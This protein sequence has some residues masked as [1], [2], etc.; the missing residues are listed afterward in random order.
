[1]DGAKNV[2]YRAIP[3][4]PQYRAGSDGSIIG[5]SG[6]LLRLRDNNGYLGFEVQID[7]RG[8]R[9]YAHVAVCEAFHGRRPAGKEVAH[10]NGVRS[11][12]RQENLSWKTRTENHADKRDHGTHRQGEGIPWAKLTEDQVREIRKTEG[13]TPVLGRRYGVSPAAIW[14]IKSGRNWKHVQ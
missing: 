11:D 7:K 3:S 12:N 1:M 4:Y 5:K 8:V 2:E 14:L 9:M 6:R 10:R 13:S